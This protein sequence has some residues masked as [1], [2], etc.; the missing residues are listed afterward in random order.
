MKKVGFDKELYESIRSFIRELYPSCACIDNRE[1]LYQLMLH[2]KKNEHPGVNFT[3]LQSIGEF[4]VNQ[5]CERD[6]IIEA[7]EQI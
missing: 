4:V 3:L 5:Y 6:E 2:D 1:N 7:L